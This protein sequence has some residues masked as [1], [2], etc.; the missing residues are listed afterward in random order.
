MLPCCGGP[1]P[2]PEI[3][4]QP[5][6]RNT[7]EGMDGNNRVLR[8]CAE[9]MQ[10]EQQGRA[11]EAACLFMDAWEQSADDFEHCVAA[12]YVA[13]HQKTP[14]DNLRWNQLSLDHADAIDDP[15]VLG[16]YPSIYLNVGWAYEDMGDRGEAKKYY[17]LAANR[18]DTLPEG[19]YRETVRAS[20]QQGLKRV[21]S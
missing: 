17:E 10:L 18:L 16:F 4:H 7:L 5:S 8:L 12:H 2:A 11:E 13:R 6:R 15:R 20:I 9:G 1:E 14:E 21:G 3:A 19:A